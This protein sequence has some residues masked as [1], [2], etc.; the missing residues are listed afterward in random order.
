MSKTLIHNLGQPGLVSC[1][2]IFLNEEIYL[3]E[4]VESILTQTYDR[5]ELI[6]VDD[7]S[8]DRS[9]EIAR[10]Y[11]RQHPEKIRYLTHPEHRNRGMSASRNL[12]LKHAKGEYVA[13]LDGD[14]LWLPEK[15]DQQVAIL[16][17]Y[18]EAAMVY[19]R[20][21][22]WYS[23]T[24]NPADQD[25]DNFADLG[26][27]PNRLLSPAEL[28]RLFLTENVQRPTPF[29]MLRRNVFTQ[30]GYFEDS[31][32][33]MFEDMYLFFKV[34]AN[35]P[36][37]I[38]DS[39]WGRYRQHPQS[40][41]SNISKAKYCEKGL[42]LINWLDDYLRNCGFEDVQ[43]WKMIRKKQ[44]WYRHPFFYFLLIEQGP[45]NLFLLSLQIGRRVIP[46]AQRDWL[47][48]KIGHR[49]HRMAFGK[50]EKRVDW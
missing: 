23:W 27:K 16:E 32:R 13:F 34:A 50:T 37:Y 18:P 44:F 26:T 7:G 4:A 22:F 25:R 28:L 41:C 3:K 1:I 21:Q 35:A 48:R 33:G 20:V 2:I 15:L 17:H 12:G 29:T 11:A 36:A 46:K 40:Y 5:W 42:V 47:W 49:L 10:D 38:S 24:G 8:T 9:R 14:D 6:F 45:K 43:T 31:V 19:G 30:I 39:Y